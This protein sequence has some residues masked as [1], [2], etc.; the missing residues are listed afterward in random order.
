MTASANAGAAPEATVR[1]P[2]P[3]QRAALIHF[4]LSIAIFVIV[5][6]PLLLM[7][8]PPPLFFSDG[9]W[10]VIRIAF[11]VDLGVGPLLT[12]VVF[13][14]G[15]KGLK[16]DLT[17]IAAMQI[18]ALV[19][20]VHLMYQERPVFL[21][22]AAEEYG[23][24][25]SSILEGKR[26]LDELQSLDSHHPPRVFVRLPEDHAKVLQLALELAHESKSIF[27]FTDWYEPMTPA[28]LA[29][30]YA[31]ALDMNRLVA[32]WPE[33]KAAYEA[34]VAERGADAANLVYLPLQCRE[35]QLIV[36]IDRRN[37]EFSAFL[38]IPLSKSNLL[39]RP[40]SAGAK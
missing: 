38:H 33:Y 17:V 31:Q 26:P 11:G 16:F 21:V 39:N 3:R 6:T 29:K 25:T 30:V 22:F 14:Q 37:G 24:I 5:V 36:A 23:T 8:Y 9:G 40:T 15:K 28:N 35:E 12:L 10:T 7:W 1:D 27:R 18:S 32:P 19:W 20:G 34:L 2:L 13:K 4:S